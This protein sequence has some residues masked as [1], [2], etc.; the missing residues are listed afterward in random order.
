M[1]FGGKL[2]YLI[3]RASNQLAV[4]HFFQEKVKV[5]KLIESFCCKAIYRIIGNSPPPLPQLSPQHDVKRTKSPIS[6]SFAD[7]IWY[8]PEQ[9]GVSIFPSPKVIHAGLLCG[10]EEIV[11][12]VHFTRVAAVIGGGGLPI[13]R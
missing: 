8:I 11:D 6:T 2:V 4:K 5:T 9:E 10:L 12:F 7:V 13:M 3:V 1:Y